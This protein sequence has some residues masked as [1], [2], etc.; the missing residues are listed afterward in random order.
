MKVLLVED[1]KNFLEAFLQELRTIPNLMV[2][3]AAS[4]ASACS[5]L[6]HTEYDL[7]ICDL[8]IPTEDGGLDDEI[9]HGL[10]VK[11]TASELSAGTPLIMFS[12]YGTIELLEKWMQEARRED[13]FGKC[14]TYPML[15]HLKKGNLPDC[16]RKVREFAHEVSAFDDVEV[17]DGMNQINL[18]W[19]E[20]RVL[21]IFARR[22]DGRVIRV[23]KLSG[24]LSDSRILR[25][26]VVNGSGAT[27]A[28]TV[29]KLAKIDAVEEEER[30]YKTH[31]VP[32]LNVGG[33][34]AV[35]DIVRAG[36]GRL[37][38]LFYRFAE[39][40]DRSLFQIL[41]ESPALAIVSIANLRELLFPWRDGAPQVEA[42]I[43]DIRRDLVKDEQLFPRLSLLNGIPWQEFEK[44]RVSI[45]LCTLHR[46]L[47]GLNVLV[48]TEG[49]PLPIDYGEVGKGP[50]SLDPL[51]L[52]L[53]LIFHPA[54]REIIGDWPSVDRAKNWSDISNYVQDCPVA[55]YISKCRTWAAEDGAGNR[56]IFA[57]AYAYAMRQLK[58]E[59]TDHAIA[60]A[61]ITSVIAA[62]NQ[63]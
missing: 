6:Q 23:S 11:S 54:G 25:V 17:S 34:T 50:G 33:L 43:Q 5:Q 16:I 62:F 14:S 58:Y 35:T 60:V 7:I 19:A 39:T 26:T 28:K 56:E 59:D 4:R 12:A 30:R 13:I 45:R 36:A 48:D 40:Y 42:S 32:L 10:A 55:E 49:R 22:V 44:K 46:D 9:E 57:A 1:D 52:E 61:L 37:G 29:G 47:H 15:S 8:R 27:K 51:T 53:S 2:T 41:K 21:R 31:V 3:V 18:S 20:K 63:T 24:G 38:G